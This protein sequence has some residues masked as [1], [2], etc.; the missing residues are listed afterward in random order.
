MMMQPA[1]STSFIMAKTEFLFEVLLSGGIMQ[2]IPL[3]GAPAAA[4]HAGRAFGTG[5]IA[6]DAGHRRHVGCQAEAPSR[7]DFAHAPSLYP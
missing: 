7:L 3:P 5:R 4:R 1:P 2:E 6:D